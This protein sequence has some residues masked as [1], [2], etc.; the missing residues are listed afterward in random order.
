MSYDSHI[1]C[2]MTRI[3]RDAQMGLQ[4]EYTAMDAGWSRFFEELASLL[5]S[6]SR[7]IGVANKRYVI[8]I[9]KR[10]ENGL[11]KLDW[12]CE[13]LSILSQPESELSPYEEEVVGRYFEMSSSLA[14]FL[15]LLLSYWDVY[16]NEIHSRVFSSRYQVGTVSQARGRP[17]FD[18][19]K[20]QLEYLDV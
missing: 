10:L 7:Q 12:V 13:T 18:V 5:D 19:E 16:L 15:R 4:M 9:I 11:R 3:S 6:C 2:H 14:S 20:S 8:Y 17:T 1:T